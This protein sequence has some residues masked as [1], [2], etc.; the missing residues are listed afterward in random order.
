MGALRDMRLLR[1][2]GLLTQGGRLH[3]ESLAWRCGF[4]DA[5]GFSKLFRARFGLSPTEWHQRAHT[6][7][8]HERS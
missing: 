1:A 4:A 7:A 2:Q 3:V 8:Y 5:S 6:D